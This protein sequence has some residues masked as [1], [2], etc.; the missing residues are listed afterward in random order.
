MTNE[1]EDIAAQETEQDEPL[2]AW[3]KYVGGGLFL[4]AITIGFYF[5]IVAFETGDAE[6]VRIW[7]PVALLYNLAGKWPVIAIGA[8]FGLGSVAVGVKAYREQSNVV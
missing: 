5:Y 1:N 3:W 7:A 6:S 4:W 8:L 2:D